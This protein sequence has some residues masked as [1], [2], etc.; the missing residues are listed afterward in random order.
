M[1][2]KRPVADDTGAQQRRR[3]EVT[4]SLRQRVGEVLPGN[5]ILSV[6]SIRLV[7]REASVHAQVLPARDTEI[8][9]A[10]C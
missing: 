3:L 5:R 1:T 10:A 7:A 9:G 2:T 6:T 4:E 8:T